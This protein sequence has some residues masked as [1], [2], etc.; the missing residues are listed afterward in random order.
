MV[1][2]DTE[3]MLAPLEAVSRKNPDANFSDTPIGEVSEV[4]PVG[5]LGSFAVSPVYTYT[6]SQ[7]NIAPKFCLNLR[8]FCHESIF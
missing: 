5:L 1:E 7:N 2:Q 3:V 6:T 4:S 8:L